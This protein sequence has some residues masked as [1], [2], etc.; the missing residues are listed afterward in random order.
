MASGVKTVPAI[1]IDLGT[2]VSFHD[3]LFSQA[4]QDESDR[5]FCSIIISSLTRSSMAVSLGFL[6]SESV[7]PWLFVLC[8]KPS[9]R[10][11]LQTPSYKFSCTICVMPQLI[12]QHI[13]LCLFVCLLGCSIVFIVFLC[14]A[15]LCKWALWPSGPSCCS[16]FSTH[17]LT[18][19]TLLIIHAFSWDWSR[20]TPNLLFPS[21][22]ICLVPADELLEHIL[23]SFEGVLTQSVTALQST[24]R[25]LLCLVSQD[26]EG[27]TRQASDEVAYLYIWQWRESKLF[28]VYVWHTSWC[29]DSVV[30]TSS[31][32]DQSMPLHDL[33]HWLKFLWVFAVQLRWYLAEWQSGDHRQWYGQ[34]YNT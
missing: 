13:C 1:G 25:V 10:K 12:C 34:P 22:F 19:Y 18:M 20:L 26:A 31:Y 28:F 3:F 2:T 29:W 23:N 16:V 6:G 14:F 27:N 4:F 15:A 17:K 32:C 24:N 30:L 11:D 7:I 8:V 33:M 9:F 5:S 21:S